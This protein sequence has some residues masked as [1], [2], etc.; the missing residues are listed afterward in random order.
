M[1]VKFIASLCG[2]SEDYHPGDERDIE[3]AQALRL[4][5]ADIAVPKSK[6]EYEQVLASVAKSNLDEAEKL[7]QVSAILEKEV[8]TLELI[9][10]YRQVAYKSAQIE[11]VVL[12]DEEVEAFVEKSMN[13]EDPAG[14]ESLIEEKSKDE[15]GTESGADKTEV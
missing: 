10:L 6:K 11:G 8:L 3:D 4:I 13:G 1:R 5:D 7:A 14:G 9:D 2:G 12:T 15:S